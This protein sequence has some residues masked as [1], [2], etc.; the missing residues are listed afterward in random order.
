MDATKH[1][2]LQLFARRLHP[3]SAK[4]TDML[5]EHFL[6]QTERR[7]CGYT[8]ATRVMAEFI[9]EARDHNDFDDLRLF[10]DYSVSGLKTV[11]QQ[12]AAHHLELPCGWRNLDQNPQVSALLAQHPNPRDAYE[13]YL[14]QEV[15]FQHTLRAMASEVELEESKLLCELIEDIVLPK[16]A[17]ALGLSSVK[18]LLE[19]PKVGSCPM[20]EKFFLEIAHRKLLRLGEINIFVD[21]H[22]QP[23]ML[24]KMNMGD[25]HS[26]INL[27]PLMMNGVRIPP[28]CLFS[29]SYDI[30]TLEKRPN[31]Q[32]KGWVI[33]I[34]QCEGFRF[35]RLT[36]LAVSPKNRARAF[37][38][39]FQQ[40]V[41]NG[42]FSPE[43]VMMSQLVTVAQEQV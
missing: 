12:A 5:N 24:E 15:A 19:K 3:L 38:T 40:Q 2:I 25:N 41:K 1:E 27:V 20:A 22:N 21:Q 42:L 14:K 30:D 26:C 39:H 29:T 17:A 32:L 28:G 23:L 43:S 34:D 10:A 16:D 36:T 31:R 8:Q 37:S 18:T 33:P 11:V 6:H 35:L 4:L 13:S 9:N 7:G